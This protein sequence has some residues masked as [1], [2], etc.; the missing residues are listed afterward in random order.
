MSLTYALYIGNRG[1]FP[2]E[3][4]ESARNEMIAAIK[5]AGCDCIYPDLDKTRYGA[6]ETIAEG[7]IFADFLKENDGKYQGVIL[8]LP[9]FGD[10]NGAM[11]ALKDVNVPILVQAYPDEMGKMDFA[12]RRDA[13]CGK[14]AMCN[15]LRQAGIKFTQTTD[16]VSTPS[17]E[18]FKKDLDTFERICRVVN[19]MKSFNVGCIGARTSAFKT[20]RVDEIALQKAGINVETIDLSE[21]FARMKKVDESKIPAMKEEILAITN[22]GEW[23]DE[24]L[25]AIAKLEIV[26]EDLVKELNL[27]AVGIRCWPEF[28]TELAIAPCLCLCLLN[29]KG[30]AAACETDVVNA[31]MMRAL[32]LAGDSAVTLLDFNNNYGEEKDKAIMFHCG[33][34]PI[35]MMEEKGE[36]IEHLMFKKTYGPGSGAGVN[37]AK[38]RSGDITWGSMRTEN[39]KVWAFVSDGKFTDDQFDAEFFGSGKVVEKE[40][41]N[42]ICKYMADNGYKHHVGI[43]LSNSKAAIVEAFE[44]YLGIETKAF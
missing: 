33:P 9:N 37:K 22:F 1:F 20:V 10:E 15:A 2:G 6:I 17:S 32:S 31:A 21:V 43:S 42:D 5:A 36:T 14:F 24:K 4:I 19:G 23:P 13:M 35:N 29:Q 26:L 41:I 8:C 16:F 7:K 28:Q 39:G 40:G 18:S 3:V 30:I 34:V 38:I 12:H 27:H 25:T 44:K 11:V